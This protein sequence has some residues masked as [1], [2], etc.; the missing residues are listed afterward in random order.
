LDHEER[1]LGLKQQIEASVGLAGAGHSGNEGVFFEV[2][3]DQEHSIIR[4]AAP[5]V[6]DSAQIKRAAIGI[7]Q[8]DDEVH[9]LAP[10]DALYFA[11]RQAGHDGQLIGGEQ[12]AKRVAAVSMQTVEEQ[13]WSIKPLIGRGHTQ[14]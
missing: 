5:T 13:V 11:L 1:Q 6:D 9:N 12:A 3:L 2:V 10:P 14:Q 4:I 7:G 8:I